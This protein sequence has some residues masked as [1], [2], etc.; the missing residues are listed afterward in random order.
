[1]SRNVLNLSAMLFA[2]LSLAG[3]AAPQLHQPEPSTRLPSVLQRSSHM[4]AIAQKKVAEVIFVQSHPPVVSI[5]P[6]HIRAV[7]D[8]FSFHWSGSLKS[9]ALNLAAAMGWSLDIT[10]HQPLVYPSVYI[11]QHNVTAIRMVHVINRQAMPTAMLRLD[12][13]TRS[14]VLTVPTKQQVAAWKQRKTACD[15]RKLASHSLLKPAKKV[16][17]G[18][19]MIAASAASKVS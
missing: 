14:I 10:N 9:V 4:A 13:T 17:P 12:N 7:D 18:F 1:M 19:P 2:G 6:S 8:R 5:A 11:D 16:Y 15:K 3:C